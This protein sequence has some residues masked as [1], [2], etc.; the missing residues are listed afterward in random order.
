MTE[1]S[2]PLDRSLAGR[3][4]APANDRPGLA[5]VIRRAL[6]GRCPNC[7]QGKLF[8]SYLKQ[9]DSCAACSERYGHIRSDDAAPW[10]TILVVGHIAVPIVFAVERLTS[11]PIWLAMTVWPAFALVLGLVVLPRAKAVLLSIIWAIQ[12]PGSE[13]Q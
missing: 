3:S 9:V 6:I 2:A 8:A 13:K 10:L 5:I 4:S 11:W 7:G 12:A 1:P